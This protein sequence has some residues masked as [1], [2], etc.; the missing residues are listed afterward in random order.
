MTTHLDVVDVSISS[1]TS[2]VDA[3][4]EHPLLDGSREYSIEVTEFTCPLGAETPLPRDSTFAETVN[5]DRMYLFKV[6]RRRVGRAPDALYTHLNDDGESSGDDYSRFDQF[7]RFYPSSRYPIQSPNDIILH[8]QN[9]LDNIKARYEQTGLNERDHGSPLGN[10][11]LDISADN[12]CKVSMTSNGT[13]QFLC[14]DLFTKHFY[15]Q[16]SPFSMNL[17]GMTTKCQSRYWS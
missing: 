1:H 10:T 7:T 13:I 4:L 14:S 12:F 3:I 8:S 2:Q 6:Y 17:F 16:F 5:L 9:F 15:I 11:A